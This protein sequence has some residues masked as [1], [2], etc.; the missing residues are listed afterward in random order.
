MKLLKDIWRYDY[1]GSAE[2]EWGAVPKSLERIVDCIQKY[3]V[4]E[5]EVTGKYKSWDKSG[6]MEEKAQVYF[7]CIKE[8]EKEVCEWIRKFADDTK[9]DYQT[10]ESVGLAGTIC[11]HQYSKDNG[12]WHDI[13]NHYLFF[14]DKTMFDG[15]CKLMGLKK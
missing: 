6:D 12:G 15:F 9:R 13:D 10:K 7:V 8:D 14:T 3:V 11:K 4:G 5:I 1:M 2:F